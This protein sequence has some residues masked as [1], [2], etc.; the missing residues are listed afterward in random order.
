MLNNFEAKCEK[1]FEG[2]NNTEELVMYHLFKRGWKFV[3]KINSGIMFKGNVFFV[4]KKYLNSDYYNS[5]TI[6]ENDVDLN[7]INNIQDLEKVYIPIYLD[8]KPI[9]TDKCSWY[10][11]YHDMLLEKGKFTQQQVLLRMELDDRI[12]RT[13][14]NAKKI[15]NFS[16]MLD[17]I[18]SYSKIPEYALPNF[19]YKK[20][21]TQ[22]KY[23]EKLAFEEKKIDIHATGEGV[24]LL[25]VFFRCDSDAAIH[26]NKE[27]FSYLRNILNV[28][29]IQVLDSTADHVHI[30]LPIKKNYYYKI[31]GVL[32]LD[33]MEQALNVEKIVDSNNI[34][35]LEFIEFT[36][37]LNELD[38]SI[39]KLNKVYLTPEMLDVLDAISSFCTGNIVTKQEAINTTAY[40]R[41]NDLKIKMLPKYLEEFPLG[42][43]YKTVLLDAVNHDVNFTLLLSNTYDI[44]VYERINDL[45]KMRIDPLILLGRNP[46]PETL[47]KYNKIL[48][49]GLAIDFFL[50][51]D[52]DIKKIDYFMNNLESGLNEE[53]V[54]YLQN[55]FSQEQIETIKWI[56]S[57]QGDS[58]IIQTTDTPIKLFLKKQLII[59]GN[60]SHIITELLNSD[61]HTDT[62]A[63]IRFIDLEKDTLKEIAAHLFTDIDFSID[64]MPW[65]EIMQYILTK[66]LDLCCDV[67]N[68][69]RIR[70]KDSLF[71]K[72][73]YNTITFYDFVEPIL[74]ILFVNGKAIFDK[75]IQFSNYLSV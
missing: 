27:K 67:N 74:K 55:G 20:I 34:K 9:D 3:Y 53:M 57:C 36:P 1:L 37:D 10:V 51:F 22:D 25:Q 6:E 38:V 54:A 66:S 61:K 42:N 26:V 64:G 35:I 56:K 72:F 12:P 29:N 13:Q 69:I 19:Q 63:E 70:I 14:Q 49:K 48:S 32:T 11:S 40:V 2:I 59:Y 47:D 45:L 24:N 4:I 7:I 43:S 15:E 75:S 16:S 65:E 28:L 73:D 50:K 31:L 18:D 39:D 21:I 5:Y 62:Y 23:V 71:M 44:Q 46:I 8:F 68:G 41:N 52:N 17:L 33:K 60:Y 30:K 58:D